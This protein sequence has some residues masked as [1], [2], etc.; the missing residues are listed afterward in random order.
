MI[1]VRSYLALLSSNLEGQSRR[2]GALAVALLAGLGLQLYNPQLLRKVIDG[3]LNGRPQ[4][5]L[6]PL[7]ALFVALALAGQAVVI[8]ATWLAEDVGWRATNRMRAELTDHVLH[9]DMGFHVTH[10]PGHLIERVDGDVTALSNFF[11]AMIVKVLGNGLLIVGVIVLVLRESWLLGTVVA[12]LVAA[13]LAGFARLHG[14]AVPWW[15]ELSATHAEVSGQVGE[16]V[17][18]TEDILPNGASAFMQE[19]FAARLREVLPQTVRGWTGF[20]MMWAT[21]QVF[22][23]A[24]T[25]AVFVI[26]AWLF[27]T[28][29]V[30]V[31]TVFLVLYYVGMI[32]RP[33]HQLRDQ[34]QDLQKAG[35]ALARIEDLR[36][37]EPAL[38]PGGGTALAPGPL[39]LELCHVGFT[40]TDEADASRVLH[41]LDLVIPAGRT[42]GVVGR[43]G[44][45]KS[46]LAKLAVRLFEP[47][48]GDIRLGGVPIGAVDD[49]RRH[50]GMVTQDVQ[51]FRASVRDNLTFFDDTL[52]DRRL[53]EV[54]DELELG[55]WL[56]SL[57][58]GLDT[59]LDGD[60][61]SA[62][63]AQLLAFARI[64]LR[65]PGLV[66]L[67][68]ASSRLDPVTEG[69]LQRAV[70]RLLEERT[71]IVIAHRLH[72]LHRVDDVLVLEAGRVVEHGERAAL[73][74]DPDSRFARL[75][76][77]GMEEV[78]A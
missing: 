26:G 66:V 60:D 74:A 56:A 7:A 37:V 67:D 13:A 42:L 43:T 70:D 76:A 52:T 28:G 5:E 65:D 4:D 21:S 8:V 20:A 40:Y 78:L 31:G 16:Q 23:S 27:G 44:S 61:L 45:G 19:R 41:D 10:A 6:V 51:L 72:T 71:A 15:K 1:P 58:D 3:A 62:G 64:F 22:S 9:L 49:L 36:A 11:S 54:L 63:Q 14:I 69:L 53:R 33:L 47:E 32:E 55:P 24:T 12:L 77:T 75:L 30:T 57:P 29:S 18:G 38:S 34:F 48:Q 59:V 2:V 35:G 25:V 39:T 46:T 68:E 17:E 50:V 73:A